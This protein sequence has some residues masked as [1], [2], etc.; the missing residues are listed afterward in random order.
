[1]NEQNIIFLADSYKDLHADMMV[2]GTTKSFSYA[3]PRVGGQY[4]NVI[5]AGL[6]YYL[7]RYFCGEVVNRQDIDEAEIV[8]NEH[9]KFCGSNL[10]NRSRWDYIAQKYNGKLPIEIKALPEG[11]RVPEGNALFTVENT[12]ENCAW[13]GQ[14]LET[15]LQNVWYPTTVCTRSFEIVKMLKR[16]LK[17]TASD[18]K[19]WL[20]DYLLHDFGQRATTC[21]EQAGIGGLAHLFNS[22]GTDTKM[23]I[24]FACNYYGANIQDLCY[25][26]SASEHSI[27]TALGPEG[28]FEV[29]ARLLK[30]YKNGILSLVSDSYDIVNAVNKYCTD[31]KPLILARNGKLVIRPDSPRYAADTP[32][33]QVLW[34]AEQLWAAYGGTYNEKGYRVLDSHVGIIYGDSLTHEQIEECLTALNDNLFSTECCVY[35]CGGYLLQKL[36]RDTQR[37]SI[38]CSY[39]ERN[40]VG[41]NIRKNPKDT[42]KKSKSGRL[43]VIDINSVLGNVAD[44]S[45]INTVE[46][47]TYQAYKDLLVPVFRNG[48]LLVNHNFFDIRKRVSNYL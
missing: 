40:G 29:T 45:G 44:I 22:K 16:Y 28:E 6:Q 38:K 1:M 14:Y 7:K 37:F 9:F 23:A 19:Q 20:G 35:G 24:P 4:P 15:T 41:I 18:D 12:D 34:I 21:P 13:L 3:E 5:F 48:E 36:N 10:W 27:A 43:K 25:S 46:E 42:S 39:Q 11:M 30:Q 17:L 33:R 31:L 26:V 2:E 32:A 8:L 47:S